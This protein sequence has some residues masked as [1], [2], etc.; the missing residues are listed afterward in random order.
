MAVPSSTNTNQNAIGGVI[1]G[2]DPVANTTLNALVVDS[3]GA[4]RI[5][6]VTIIY[7]ANPVGT[8]SIATAQVNVTN[9]VTNI[10]NARVGNNGIGRVAL[11]LYNL[12]NNMVYVGNTSVSLGNGIPLSP[13]GSLTLNTTAAISGITPSGNSVI[14]LLENY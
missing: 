5:E 1:Y 13:G 11:T 8:A 7:A 4:I 6:G 12:G 2:F 3:N 10:V 14:S 9:A